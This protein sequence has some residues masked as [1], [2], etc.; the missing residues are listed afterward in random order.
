MNEAIAPNELA[1]AELR[2]ALDEELARLGDKYR[3]P[4]VLCYLEGLT[5]Q[6]AAQ[7]LGWPIGTVAGRL[8]RA[9]DLLRERM[10]RRDPSYAPPALTIALAESTTTAVPPTLILSTT[11]AAT[12]LAAG[13]ASVAVSA[14]VAALTNGVIKAM[15]MTKLKVALL[16]LGMATLCGGGGLIARQVLAS[17]AGGENGD[18][19]KEVP[20]DQPPAPKRDQPKKEEPKRLTLKEAEN[21]VTAHIFGTD[22]KMSR[23][24]RFP[25]TEMT[26]DD[27]WKRLG[28]QVYQVK[29]PPQQGVLFVIK[30]DEVYRI[31]PGGACGNQLRSLCVADLN[32]DKRLK[33]IYSFSW[34]SG[35]YRSQIGVFDCLAKEPKQVVA[36]YSY[37]NGPDDLILKRVD[38]QT[39]KV[40]A[41]SGEVGKVTLEGKEGELKMN[42]EFK[43]DLPKKVKQLFRKLG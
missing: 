10:A 12:L 15:W 19:A 32:G 9:L 31:G 1:Q 4:I 33:L 28:I 42:V 39:V 41:K 25:L 43:E 11:K 21:A 40:H 22:P 34:G 38:D 23:D 26:T 37:F 30:K 20:A 13:Q 2:L 16:I 8:S 29:E 7:L 14:S 36:P 6:E 27:I 18:A 17:S 35:E 5:R 24:A 3:K